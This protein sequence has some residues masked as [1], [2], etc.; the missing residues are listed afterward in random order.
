MANDGVS[1]EG[2]AGPG[3]AEKDEARDGARQGPPPAAWGAPILR[4]QERW[5]QLEIRLIAF[6]LGWQ[7]VSLVAWVA[8]SGLGARPSADSSAGSVFRSGVGALALGSAAWWLTRK[9]PL[10]TRRVATVAAVVVGL[11]LGP[12]W[13][14]VGVEYFDNIKG[15]LQEGST[16]TLMGGLRGLATRLT[17]WLA[18]L[19]GSLATGLGKHIHVDLVARFLPERARRPVALV[20]HLAAA[21]VCAA[22]AWG[23]FDF[24]AIQSYG[25]NAD[26]PPSAKLAAA[27]HDFG[28]HAFYL[29]K[30]VGLDLRSLPHVLRGERY[31]AWMTNAEWNAWV[32][33]AGFDERYGAER[34]KVLLVD[35]DGTHPTLVVPPTGKTARGCLVEDL[36]LVFPFG[37]LAIALRFLVR[38]LLTLSGHASADPEEAVKDEIAELSH[39]EG[40]A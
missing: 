7:L 1:P 27:A 31:D 21:C 40:G 33:A 26:A 18:L 37:L 28:D 3:P 30:Q 8:V 12:R 36:N 39:A 22:A 10:T 32:K 6:V 13:R 16:L 35:G 29:R 23:F 24:N 9:Q 4:L 38:A 17:L 5:T 2:G 15:W 11:A 34:T 25:A 20:N 19:G 14:T